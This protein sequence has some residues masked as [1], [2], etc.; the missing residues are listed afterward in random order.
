[1]QHCCF[2]W[3]YI[4]VAAGSSYSIGERL[5]SIPHMLP[6]RFASKGLAVF[7]SRIIASADGWA[8]A[9]IVLEDLGRQLG[10]SVSLHTPFNHPNETTWITAEAA[11]KLFRAGVVVRNQ[12]VLLNGVNKAPDPSSCRSQH[13][14][15]TANCI[16]SSPN[17]AFNKKS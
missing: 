1:M 16:P 2:Q 14:A 5:L 13:P 10:K 4:L 12:T 8:A 9:L 3:R 11:Q 17:I 15:G 6:I 7:P